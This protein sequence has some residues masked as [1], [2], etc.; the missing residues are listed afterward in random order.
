MIP[1]SDAIMEMLHNTGLAQKAIVAVSRKL[2][3]VLWR[4]AREVRVYGQRNQR[5]D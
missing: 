2:A 5:R 3:V 4:L 1:V